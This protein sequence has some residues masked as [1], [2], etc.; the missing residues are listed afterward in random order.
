MRFYFSEV[1]ADMNLR[2]FLLS[3][4]LGASIIVVPLLFKM[5]LLMIGG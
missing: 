5:F 1:D 2:E 3:A 4:I